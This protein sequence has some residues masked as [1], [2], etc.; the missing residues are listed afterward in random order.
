MKVD[1]QDVENMEL[2]P[3]WKKIFLGYFAKDDCDVM[4]S[5]LEDSVYVF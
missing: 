4:E 5:S 3:A 1:A 2:E